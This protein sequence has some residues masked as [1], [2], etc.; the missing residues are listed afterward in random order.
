MKFKY[1]GKGIE[2]FKNTEINCLEKDENGNDLSTFLSAMNR[3]DDL[4]LFSDVCIFYALPYNS[5]AFSNLY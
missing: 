1:N 3:C 4:E 2:K 5:L